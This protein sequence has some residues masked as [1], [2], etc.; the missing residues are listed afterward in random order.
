MSLIKSIHIVQSHIFP[1]FCAR[2]RNILWTGWNILAIRSN[3]PSLGTFPVHKLCIMSSFPTITR[4]AR[5]RTLFEQNAADAASRAVP[6]TFG[7]DG[8][9]GRILPRPSIWSRILGLPLSTPALGEKL[10]M[11]ED[12]LTISCL[13]GGNRT[14]AQQACLQETSRIQEFL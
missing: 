11:P 14:T 13:E 1:V 7:P 9:G 10:D 3:S 4:I 2:D 6:P 12:H 8:R 5:L